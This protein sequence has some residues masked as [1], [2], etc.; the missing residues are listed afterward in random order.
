MSATWPLGR[1]EAR[2]VARARWFHAALALAAG[3]VA[4]FVVV[5]ARESA[6]LGFTG[7]GRVMGGVVQASLLLLPLLA[8]LA[9]SQSVTAARA[10]GV[11]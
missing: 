8:L 2:A 7:F 4:F 6:V 10:D 11:L 5:A 1:L 3:L 9:T